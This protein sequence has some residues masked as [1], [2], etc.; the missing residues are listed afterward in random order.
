VNVRQLLRTVEAAFLAA[1]VAGRATVGAGDLLDEAPPLEAPPLEGARDA[2]MEPDVLVAEASD[3]EIRHA[4]AV[5]GGNVSVAARA[6]GMH[7]SKLRRR[8]A[9]IG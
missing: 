1:D 8:L 2:G 4:L 5:S 9:K 7:R 3:E 6:L